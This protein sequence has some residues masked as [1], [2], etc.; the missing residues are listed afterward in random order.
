MLYIHSLTWVPLTCLKTLAI[1]SPEIGD[2]SCACLSLT[3]KSGSGYFAKDEGLNDA[4]SNL[5][6]GY[7][8]PSFTVQVPHHDTD[9]GINAHFFTPPRRGR[10]FLPQEWLESLL[11]LHCV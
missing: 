9:L 10:A 7:S 4:L 3:K 8:E 1:S 11:L 2:V 5:S 6:E